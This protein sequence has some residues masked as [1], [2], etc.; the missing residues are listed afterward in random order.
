MKAK[1]NKVISAVTITFAI[2]FSCRVVMVATPLNP[3]EQVGLICMA[4]EYTLL[5]SRKLG[6]KDETV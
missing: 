3:A 1:L 4:I 2:V 6:D 5:K